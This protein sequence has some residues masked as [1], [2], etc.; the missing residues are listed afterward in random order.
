MTWMYL[1]FGFL[2]LAMFLPTIDMEVSNDNADINGDDQ[3]NRLSGSEISDTIRGGDD[4]LIGQAG[5]DYLYS[6]QGNDTLDGGA[7]ED[8]LYGGQGNDTLDG[9]ADEDTLYGGGQ[10]DWRGW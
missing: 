1:V 3:D 4:T 6:E 7:D 9:D 8:T 5:N 2:G 10:P